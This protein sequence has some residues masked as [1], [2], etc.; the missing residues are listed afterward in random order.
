MRPLRDV[1]QSYLSAVVTRLSI[2]YLRSAQRQREEYIGPWL[3]EPLVSEPTANPD[4]MLALSESL[5]T[6]FL[7]ILESLKPVERAVFL[8][9]EVFDY[10][11]PAIAQ[12][13]G[14]SEAN[15]RQIFSRAR[16]KISADR[17]Q[18]EV[19]PSEQSQTGSW[20]CGAI[21]KR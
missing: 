13:V 2:D 1:I 20:K 19:S 11:Y 15:C 8:L 21:P 5:S 10:D 3:P 6:A 18:F 16:R 17:P 4:Q 9:R 14:K 12:I 7:V